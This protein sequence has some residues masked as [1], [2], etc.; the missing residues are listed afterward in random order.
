MYGIVMP[1]FF[2]LLHIHDVFLALCHVITSVRLVISDV[3]NVGTTGCSERRL[4]GH[5]FYSMAPRTEK[6]DKPV[7]AF[8]SASGTALS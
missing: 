7:A 6:S 4:I 5:S 2:L 8:F 3:I 1:K